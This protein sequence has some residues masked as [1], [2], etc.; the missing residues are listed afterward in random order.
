MADIPTTLRQQ[1]EFDI[2]AIG[3]ASHAANR[4][5]AD[6]VAR[7]GETHRRYHSQQH[8]IALFDLLDQHASHL[9]PGSP[10][11][12]AVWWHDLVYDPRAADNEEQSANIARQRLDALGAKAPIID[13]TVRLIL[14][15]KNHWSGPTAG[16]GDYFLDADI[17][18][19][20]APSD[21][22]DAYAIAVRQEYAFAPDDAYRAGRSNFLK[23]VLERPRIFRTGAFETAYADQAR[24]NIRRELAAFG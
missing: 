5:L 8:L 4:V 11:R 1:W 19:L 20:G 6:I 12:L 10:S 14:M 15:T 16:D 17:A 22:Y 23:A 18:I 3:A 21:I 13:E 2:A 24:A 9:L 7:H